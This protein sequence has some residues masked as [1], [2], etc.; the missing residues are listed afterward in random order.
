MSDM[1]WAFKNASFEKREEIQHAKSFQAVL[2]KGAPVF[3]G[4]SGNHILF[5]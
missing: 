4:W 1:Q 2:G 5:R 3:S